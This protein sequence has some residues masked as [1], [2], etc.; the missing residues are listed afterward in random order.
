L[1][2]WYE[3]AFRAD[4]L[5]VYGHRDDASAAAEASAWAG[6]LPGLVPGARVL[7]LACGAGRHLRALEAMG[8]RASGCDLSGDLLAEARGRGAKS[9]VRCDNRRLPFAAAAFDAVTCFFSSFGYF[10]TE[11]EDAAV[12]AEAARVLRPGGGLLLDLMDPE[13]VRR[14]LVPRT[15]RESGGLRLLEERGLAA[16]GLRVEK[17]VTLEGAGPTGTR[18]RWTE[19]V[20]LYDPGEVEGLALGAG[21]LPRGRY[22]G[23]GPRPWEGGATPRCV[24]LF[25]RKAS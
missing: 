15:E 16:G 20:R 24:L 4:Y 23:H 22:G 18:R 9:I 8:L 3:E 7:D 10:P 21:L 14:D 11:E 6:R 12:L 5:R 1:P 19:S 25:E 13:T 17:R 2:A